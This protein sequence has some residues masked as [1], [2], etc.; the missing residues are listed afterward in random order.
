[1][2][3]EV[4]ACIVMALLPVDTVRMRAVFVRGGCDWRACRYPM[5]WLYIGSISASPTTCPLRGYGHAGT[6]NDRLGVDMPSAM[7]ICRNDQFICVSLSGVDQSYISA[8]LFFA[9]G[10]FLM[11]R[12]GVCHLQE[13]GVVYIGAGSRMY[14][15]RGAFFLFR[16]EASWSGFNED[17]LAE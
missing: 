10:F 13:R 3:Y 2:A 8:R 1:M 9:R 12:S 17:E 5:G 14:Y 6:Q 7:P 11:Y 16:S 15:G 4:V